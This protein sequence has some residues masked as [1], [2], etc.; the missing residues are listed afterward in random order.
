[1]SGNYS[2]RAQEQRRKEYDAVAISTLYAFGAGL[3]QHCHRAYDF[4]ICC[5]TIG[6]T[7][8]S[9]L[10][11]QAGCAAVTLTEH[12]V[13][14]AETSRWYRQGESLTVHVLKKGENP[15]QFTEGVIASTYPEAF[16]LL[17]GHPVDIPA[18]PRA[19]H[20]DSAFGGD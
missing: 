20:R 18:N 2:C 8:E 11:Y 12:A 14:N 3:G 1:L 19:P 15:R 7:M 16:E 9:D 5:L 6:G 13:Y 10:M 4:R 17:Y